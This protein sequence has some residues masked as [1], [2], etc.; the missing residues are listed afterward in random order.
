MLSSELKNVLIVVFLGVV[1]AIASPAQTFRTLVNFDGTDG[2]EPVDVPLVQGINGNLYGTTLGG[3]LYGSGTVFEIN[4]AGKTIILYN[5]CSQSNCV[6]GSLPY[7][8]LV[9]GRDGN[10]YG[11]TSQGGAN[12]FGTV[13]KIEPSGKLTT[14]HSFDVGD[15]AGPTSPMI[16]GSDG[17]FYGITE[18]VPTVFKITSSG[19]FTSLYS[20]GVGDGS[21]L[22]GPLVQG[23]DGNFY[24]TTEMGGAN[25]YGTIFKITPTG[26]FST[27]YSFNDV[28][29][30]TPACGLLLGSD[31]NLYGTTNIGGSS[32]NCAFGCGTAFKISL[33]GV[34]A[35]LHNFDFTSG[36]NPIAGLIQA[37]DGN[38]YGT[39]YGGGTGNWGTVYKMT[40]TGTVILLHSFQSSDGAQPYGPVTQ[41]TSGN[42]Y[43]TTPY[44]GSASE[45]TL[46]EISTGLS[47]FVSFVSNSGKVGQSVE[48]LG[49][50]LTNTTGVSFNGTPASFIVKSATFIIARVPIGA[51]TGF[52]Q[53]ATPN[54]ALQ[55]NL[56]FR[57][58]P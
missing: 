25:G 3:G 15:G 38:F 28:D 17:S 2:S 35:T 37:T 22:A 16:L 24:G 55:S 8:G 20:L 33:A 1:L 51:T 10:F 40:P 39:T 36:A 58:V 50:S 42:L 46:F 4:R 27:F 30:R 57:V 41:G 23:P 53:V 11:T 32:N 45:G 9:L 5:F 43:G 26:G 52:V 44:G 34:L 19:V 6:D 14:L 7:G 56:P 21:Q 29:G 13:F 18:N 48:I 47:P 49:Q 12:A 54:K 31:G